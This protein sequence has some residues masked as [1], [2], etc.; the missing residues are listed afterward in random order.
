MSL[1]NP[2]REIYFFKNTISKMVY[3]FM[4]LQMGKEEFYEMFEF[5]IEISEDESDKL[6]LEHNFEVVYV[7]DDHV[8]DRWFKNEVKNP[9]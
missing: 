8:I 9:K 2:S 6:V 7:G 5:A 3:V 4:S 1:K